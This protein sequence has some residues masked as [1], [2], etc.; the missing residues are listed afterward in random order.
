[1]RTEN[2]PTD[3][4]L[5]QMAKSTISTLQIIVQLV[6]VI[7]T[8]TFYKLAYAGGQPRREVKL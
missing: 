2:G 5:R 6:I 3:F 1:M 4:S 8:R 7:H